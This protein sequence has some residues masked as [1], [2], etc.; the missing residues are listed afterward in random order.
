MEL[1]ELLTQVF[2]GS[3]SAQ[4]ELIS[5]FQDFGYNIKR[6]K[7]EEEKKMLNGDTI[8]DDRFTV[9]EHLEGNIYILADKETGV[10]YLSKG[11]GITVL[12]D[13]DGKPMIWNGDK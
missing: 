3:L 7:I 1:R 6:I 11:R 13:A 12:M 9:M 8:Y 5:T 10:M 2:T 4:I